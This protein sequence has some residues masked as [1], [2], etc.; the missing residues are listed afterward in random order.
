MY[1]RYIMIAD[2]QALTDNPRNS[3]RIETKM[4]LVKETERTTR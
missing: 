4:I 2:Q 1:N 3:K